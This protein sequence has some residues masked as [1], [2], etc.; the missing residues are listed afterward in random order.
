MDLASDV[1]VMHQGRCIAAG[2]PDEM[3]RN[4]DVRLAFL[5]AAV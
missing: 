1:T 5:G 3:Q 4:D 2:T